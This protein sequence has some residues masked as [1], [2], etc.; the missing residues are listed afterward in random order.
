MKTKYYEYN[1]HYDDVMIANTDILE[2]KL[3]NLKLYFYLIV[4]KTFKKCRKQPEIKH[5][6]TNCNV[7]PIIYFINR[8]I[9]TKYYE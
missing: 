6:P 2:S 4:I 3:I 9:E 7:T 1:F 5:T 8:K